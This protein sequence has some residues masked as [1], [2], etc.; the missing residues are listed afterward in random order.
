MIQSFMQTATD[1]PR[2]WPGDESHQSLGSDPTS[3]KGEGARVQHGDRE[4]STTTQG[5]CHAG[6]L[7]ATETG[8]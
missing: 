5:I 6:D 1:Q 8:W 3:K 2:V 4:G 7:T